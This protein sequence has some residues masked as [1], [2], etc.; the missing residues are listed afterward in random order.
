MKITNVRVTHVNIPLDAPFWWTAG[1]YG[2]AS[3]SIVA[4]E[5][6]AGL[7]GLGEPPWLQFG[8]GIK[9]ENDPALLCPAPPALAL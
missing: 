1:L 2:G 8:Q 7:I 3:K 9:A 6:D 5:A 4:V